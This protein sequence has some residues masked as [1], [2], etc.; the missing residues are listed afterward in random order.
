MPQPAIPKP[1]P[2]PQEAEYAVDVVFCLDSTLSMDGILV[3]TKQQIRSITDQVAAG[4]KE[5]SKTLRSF[6]ARLV[7]FRDLVEDGERQMVEHDW[8][9]LIGADGTPAT[10]EL[11]AALAGIKA[12]G[13]GDEAESSLDALCR[14]LDS[15]WLEPPEGDAVKLRKVVI[16]FT[17]NPPRELHPSSRKPGEDQMSDTEVVIGRLTAA[18]RSNEL[19]TALVGPDCPQF[20]ALESF[21]YLKRIKLDPGRGAVDMYKPEDFKPVQDFIVLSSQAV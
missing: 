6:R 17:D 13:G 8:V 11:E 12:E 9:S 2:G 18:M 15:K 7:E 1:G 19:R 21:K 10:A 3:V 20:Q 16:L 5:K 4:F 14:A